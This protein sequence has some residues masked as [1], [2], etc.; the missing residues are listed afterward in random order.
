VSASPE[1]R[2][3][4]EADTREIVALWEACGLTRPWNRPEKDIAFARGKEQSDI[5]VGV[6]EGRIVASIMVG[7]DGHRGSFYYVAVAPSW[8]GRGVG[9]RLIREGE[10]WL[11]E[12]GVWK[13]NLLIRQENSAVQNFYEQ[14]GY[15]VNKVMSMGQ[16]LIED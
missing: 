10:R 15:E 14:L 2:P 5:L 9:S 13:V 11:R 7:H 3:M 1:F 12:R 16:R 4:R 8:R 6:I